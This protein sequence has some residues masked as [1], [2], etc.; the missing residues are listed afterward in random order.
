[1]GQYSWIFHSN[2]LTEESIAV[3]FIP[4]LELTYKVKHVIEDSANMVNKRKKKV[5]ELVSLDGESTLIHFSF[6]RGA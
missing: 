6:V 1:M 2:T 5:A 3:D 4:M